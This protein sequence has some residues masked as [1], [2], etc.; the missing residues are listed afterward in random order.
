MIAMNKWHKFKPL[1]HDILQRLERLTAIF[2][3][4]DVQLTYLFG[5]LAQNEDAND[6]DLALLMTAEK[7]PYQLHT[8]IANTLE[9]ERVDIVDLRRA[10]PV[11]AYEIITTGRCI[12]AVNETIQLEFECHILR[13]YKDTAWLR[14][15]QEL[16]LKERM[17]QWSSNTIALPSDSKS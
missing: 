11:L 5:S 4:E 13:Q 1:P 14:Q 16:L 15:K 2:S 6:V 8:L 12:Y 9:I 10:S 17:K 3:T 7:R